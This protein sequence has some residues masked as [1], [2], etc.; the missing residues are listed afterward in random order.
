MPPESEKPLFSPPAAA[1]LRAVGVPSNLTG[2]AHCITGIQSCVKAATDLWPHETLKQW[3]LVTTEMETAMQSAARAEVLSVQLFIKS[4]NTTLDQFLG[5]RQPFVREGPSFEA[6]GLLGK[7]LLNAAARNEELPKDLLSGLQTLNRARQGKGKRSKDWDKLLEADFTHTGALRKILEVLPHD[8]PARGFINCAISAL[9]ASIVSPE[10]I[11]LAQPASSHEIQ[12]IDPVNSNKTK[13]FRT[14]QETQ[15]KEKANPD[16]TPD[17]AARLAAADYSSFPEKLGLPHKD[18][19]LVGD[20]AQATA[21]LRNF[22]E[23]GSPRERGFAV[24]AIA[25]A[26]TGCTDEIALMLQFRHG[27]SI[28][29]N[30]ERGAWAWDFAIFRNSRELVSM[31]RAVEPVYCPWPALIDQ[32]LQAAKARCPGAK[33]LKDLILCIQGTDHFD[34]KDFRQFLRNCGHPSHPPHRARFARSMLPIYL[35]VTGS[36]MTGA[37]MAG[38]FP[39]TAP[40]APYYFGPTYATL[41]SRVSKAYDYLGLGAPSILFSESGRAGCQKVLESA[42]LQEGWRQLTSEINLARAKAICSITKEHLYECCN[43]WMSLLCAA[44]VIQTGHRGTRLECLTAGA[45]LLHPNAMLVHDKDEGER[46]QPRLIPKTTAT[47]KILMSA[48]E[49]HLTMAGLRADPCTKGSLSLEVTDLVFVEWT[50]DQNTTLCAAISTSDVAKH[51]GKFFASD[52]NFGRSQWVTYLDED[53]CDR[54]LIRSLTGHTRDV[55]RTHGPYFDVPPLVVASRLCVE[56]E[57]TG[58]NI[59]GSTDFRIGITHALKLKPASIRRIVN[60]MPASNPIPDPRA[61]LNPLSVDTLIDWHAVEH[62][63]SDLLAGEIDAHHNVLA[64]LHLLLIDLVPLASV[65]INAITDTSNVLRTI[66]NYSGLQWQRSH[67]IHPNWYPIRD[68]S[69]RLLAQKSDAVISETELIKLVCV[70]IRKTSY[71]RWPSSDA[72]CWAVL[73]EIPIG[74]RRLDFSPSMC[75]VSSSSVAA[76]CLSELSNHRLAGAPVLPLSSAPSVRVH[77]KKSPQKSDD[78]AFLITTLGIYTSNIERHGERQARAV[79]C[80]RD[81]DDPAISWTPFGLWI[82]TWVVDELKR[83]RDDAKFCYQIST[84]QTYAITLLIAQAKIDLSI[85][86][87]DWEDDEWITWVSLTDSSCYSE[88]NQQPDNAEQQDLHPRAKSAIAAMVE[89]LRRRREYVPT[90]V[91]GQVKIPQKNIQPYGSASSHLIGA[92]DYANA[93]AIFQ[94]WHAD[95]PADCAM[96]EL[97]KMVSEMVPLRAADGSSLTTRCITPNGGLVIERVG[98]NN[99]KTDNAIRIVPLSEANASLLREKIA[100]L[101]AYFGERLLLFRGDGSP[102]SGKRDQRL[103]AD[104]SSALKEATGDVKARPHSVRAATLQEISWPGWQQIS[105]QLLNHEATADEC[106]LWL[107]GLQADWMRLS[108]AAA[109]AGQGDLRSALGHY[110]AGWLMVYAVM[111]NARLHDR[112]PGPNFLKQLGLNPDAMRQARSRAQRRADDASSINE[113]WDTWRWVS[114]QLV[115]YKGQPPALVQP[116]QALLTDHVA[117]PPTPK[118]ATPPINDTDRLAYLAIRALGLSKEE[119]LEATE[120]PLSIAMGLEHAIPPDELVAIAVRRNRQ[121]PRPRGQ[122]AN[123]DMAQSENGATLLSWLQAMDSAEY[124]MIRQVFFRGEHE[125]VRLPDK[126]TFWRQVA[127][128]VPPCLSIHVKI[129]SK[130]LT[131]AEISAL[132]QLAPAVKVLPDPRIGERPVISLFERDNKNVVTSAR[133]TAVARSYCLAIDALNKLNKTGADHAR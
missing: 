73:S 71:C 131:P 110:L 28:W 65:C 2:A 51:T 97:R 91:S 50:S 130:H 62:L 109:A 119:A 121:G 32:P 40:A 78:V 123:I 31:P 128:S 12:S 19:M 57:K 26:V 25:S 93:L 70:A 105:R 87:T 8:S 103:C 74:F 24:L 58:T 15:S 18:Q 90:E 36:D 67:F 39:A 111:A 38:F 82:K 117:H 45:L 23:N 102:A 79:K 133:L 116:N 69:V 77:N 132:T 76:P 120:I 106:Q 10:F 61:L 107:T 118:A 33:N 54:W 100:G 125:R 14:G 92:A 52:V 56:M 13:K 37:L 17:I 89:S 44:F 124:S 112:E 48:S 113:S 122:K 108:R 43:Y 29:M 64:V 22:V 88:V 114:Q 60:M 96:G 83:S 80:L 47:H 94:N 129:G 86:P 101:E 127:E 84:I 16:P 30:L 7:A 42:K 21:R 63:S 27:H 20:F 81:L 99:H 35:Y 1:L 4:E 6:N 85:D 126:V 68:T 3:T 95:Y 98:Y 11:A 66:H 9:D 46:V 72:A 5:C 41:I 49:C 104:L 75:T 115:K 53:G 55:T 34:V 59:F